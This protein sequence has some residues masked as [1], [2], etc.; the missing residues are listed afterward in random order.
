MEWVSFFLKRSDIAYKRP[1]KLQ[2]D[3]DNQILGAQFPKKRPLPTWVSTALQRSQQL[4]TDIYQRGLLAASAWLIICTALYITV[5]FT[6][7]TGFLRIAGLPNALSYVED[8]AT[9][10]AQVAQF[11][12]EFVEGLE[13]VQQSIQTLE[14]LRSTQALD[15]HPS[16]LA[17]KSVRDERIAWDRVLAEIDAAIKKT[18]QTNAITQRIVI[19]SFSFDGELRTGAL[20]NV[21][22]YADG[23]QSSLGLAARFVQA[24]EGSAL[25]KNV[26]SSN[27]TTEQET[28]SGALLSYTPLQITFAVQEAGETTTNDPDRSVEDLQKELRD[29]LTQ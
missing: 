24:L 2:D 21:K 29:L 3:T 18:V 26:T 4:P 8:A 15:S 14:Q 12:S 22:V 16:L 7:S 19:G 25:L 11:D 1:M 9:T 27:P 13:E 28:A 23:D 20:Q 5:L 10:K 17:V 6:H